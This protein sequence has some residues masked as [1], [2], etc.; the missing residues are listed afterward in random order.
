PLG[1]SF[2][3]ASRPFQPTFLPREEVIPR[4]EMRHSRSHNIATIYEEYKPLSGEIRDAMTLVEFIGLKNGR[5][6]M[7]PRSKPQVIPKDNGKDVS[8]LEENNPSIMIKD[9][10]DK[11]KLLG[12]ERKQPIESLEAPITLP[13]DEPLDNFQNSSM[14]G[15]GFDEIL[16][17]KPRE[18]KEIMKHELEGINALIFNDDSFI[19][20]DGMLQENKEEKQIYKM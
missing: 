20:N 3:T 18:E 15:Q 6:R 2:G 11:S 7:G 16:K 10:E 8:A 17:H 19:S 5:V 1:S 9:D 4:S 14:K 13:K 12:I